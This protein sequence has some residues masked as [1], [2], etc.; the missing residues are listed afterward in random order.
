MNAIP[1]QVVA[2]DGGDAAL[3]FA[4]GQTLLLGNPGGK[5]AVGDAVTIGIRPEHCDVVDSG[6]VDVEVAIDLI[7]QLGG[8]TFFYCSAAGIAGLTAQESGQL[9]RARRHVEAAVSSQSPSP[10]RRER[11]GAGV[12]RYRGHR[13]L[14][15]PFDPD[16]HPELS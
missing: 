11:A 12:R 16:Q 15:H 8:E 14:T 2:I 7:E 13:V 4:E 1:G 9:L 6:V 3:A 10:V 5:L